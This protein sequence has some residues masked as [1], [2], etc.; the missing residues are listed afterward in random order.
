MN[1]MTT[2]HTEKNFHAYKEKDR[3]RKKATIRMY[4]PALEGKSLRV[5]VPYWEYN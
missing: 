2:S 5:P 3:K 4:D 1:F